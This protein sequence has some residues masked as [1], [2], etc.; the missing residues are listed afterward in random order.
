MRFA[1]PQAVDEYGARYDR[2][3]STMSEAP[4]V[5]SIVLANGPWIL[6]VAV[7]VAVAAYF[8]SYSIEPVYR[9]EATL[10]PASAGSSNEVGLGRNIAA[11]GSLAGINLG[12]PDLP[13]PIF[14]ATLESRKFAAQFISAKNLAPVLLDE[15]EKSRSADEESD[16]QRER[17][18]LREALE[19]FMEEVFFVRDDPDTGAV[20]IAIE[21]PN[22]VLAAEWANELAVSLN[23]TIRESE[24]ADAE[25]RLSFLN[26]E[27]EKTSIVPVKQA[28]FNLV[29]R[30]VQK[31]MLANVTDE[32]AF[33][34]ID[35]AL[36]PSSDDFVWPQRVP[37]AALS[38]IL[39]ALLLVALV[40][41]RENFRP[42][43]ES[44]VQRSG[45]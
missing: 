41:A 2:G 29:E 27:I 19:I 44:R 28:L 16:E 10:M 37:I 5:H 45:K 43:I 42:P 4:P 17:E 6:C 25:R 13:N 8:L 35:P 32:Y 34:I 12:S 9:A 40:I 33:K 24:V 3:L 18:A 21:W 15:D 23:E 14:R 30:E 26:L 38:G 39:I 22:P 20:R 7:A 11:L 36:V 1:V 31:I